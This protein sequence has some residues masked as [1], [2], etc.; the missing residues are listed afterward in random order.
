MIPIPDLS[1]AT[2][3]AKTPL[4]STIAIPTSL[5]QTKKLVEEKMK[6]PEQ[7]APEQKVE[8]T[9]VSKPVQE[10]VQLTQEM[11][12]QVIHAVK[13][14]Y[15]QA[16]KN[17]ELAILDQPI[18]VINGEVFLQVMGSVQEEIANKMRPDLLGLLRKLTGANQLSVSVEHKEELQEDRPKLYT[19]TDKLRYLRD[20]HPALAEFQRKFGLDVDF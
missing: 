3:A 20:K 18:K 15:Q 17:F 5:F 6:A 1:K 13:D 19:N 2:E 9:L 10:T 11:L 8:E 4:K 7:S 14:H 16:N 12:D